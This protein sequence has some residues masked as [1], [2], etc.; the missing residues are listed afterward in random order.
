MSEDFRITFLICV[1]VVICIGLMSS[2]A[3]NIY[4]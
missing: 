1:T 2:C 3:T 4:N